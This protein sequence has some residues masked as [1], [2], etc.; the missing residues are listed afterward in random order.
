VSGPIAGR[1]EIAP[2]PVALAR[3]AAHWLVERM[4]AAP[5]DFRL[6]LSGGSTPRGLYALLGSDEFKASVPWDKLELFWGDERFV[7]PDD[8][9]SNYR[10]ARETLLNRAPMS[11]D[12]IH[13]IPTDGTPDDAARRYEA[14]LKKIYGAD[15]FDPGRPLF[16]VILLGLGADGH[17]GSLLPG[18]PVLQEKTRWVE[19]VAQGRPEARITLTYPAIESSGVMAFLVAG[20][21]KAPA[22]KGARAGDQALPAARLRPQG[23]AIW[24]LD[25]A[26]A[27]AA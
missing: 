2:D 13:P 9:E 11:A 25:R 22:V 24:F 16:D 18:Q 23:E 10:M 8:K 21:D 5:S 4:M 3:K 1:V 12:R 26:A 27:G 19:A 14:L 17:T 15:Q 20:A 7:P 6:S